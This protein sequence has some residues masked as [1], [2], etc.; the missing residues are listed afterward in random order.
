MVLAWRNGAP[1]RVRDVGVAVDGPENNRS[2]AGPLPAPPPRGQHVPQRPRD[3]PGRDQAAGRQRD[4]HGGPHQGRP[5]P[6][7]ASIP[8]AVNVNVLADRTQNIR[9]SEADVEFTLMLTIVLVVASS[10]CS[11]ATCRPR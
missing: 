7:A 5:A 8:A 4:R 2:R 10:S 9:A 3:H 6:P 1:V 11:C